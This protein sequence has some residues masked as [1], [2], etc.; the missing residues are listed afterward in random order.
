[1]R[2][3]YPA[4]TPRAAV[5]RADLLRAL[6]LREL[7]ALTLDDDGQTWFGYRRQEEPPPLRAI[8]AVVEDAY[9]MEVE[10]AP[11]PSGRR[12][13]LRMPAV[14][15]IV[16]RETRPAPETPPAGETFSP[17]DE[18]G[19]TP[20]SP[21][22]LIAYE[23]LIPAAR[24]LPALRRWLG[25]DRPGPP[26]LDRL[27]RRLAVADPPRHLPRQRLSRWHPDLVVVFDFS[28]RLWPYREDMHRLAERLLR[29]CGQYGVSPRIV[30]R[31]PPG[32]WTDWRDEQNPA[33]P[34]TA[35]AWVMPPAGTPVLIVGDGGLLLGAG[36]ELAQRWRAFIARLRQARLRPLALV[37]L[38]A[39]QLDAGLT[40]GLPVLR[41]SPDARLRP[42]RAHGPGRPEPE[43]LEDLLAMAAVPRR[44]DPPLLRALRR[45]HPATPLDAGLEGAFWRHPQVE[46]GQV[47]HVGGPDRPRHLA[48]F[49]ELVPA[50]QAA[51]ERLRARHHAHLRAV[52]HHEETLAFAAHADPALLDHPDLAAAVAESA[53]F[54]R[55]LAVTLEQGADD[56]NAAGWREAA[57]GIE[58]RAD[59]V[60][61]ER[62]KDWL[63]PLAAARMRRDLARGLEPVAPDWADPAALAE[64]LPPGP[65]VE[66]WLVRDAAG[67]GLVLQDRPA[68]PRQSS[69]GPPDA[70]LTL[71]GGGLSVRIGAER[72]RWHPADRLPLRLAGLDAADPIRLE[73]SREQLTI[74]PLVRPR[75]TAILWDCG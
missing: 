73:T 11:A 39:G 19:P 68:G 25:A 64:A 62:G 31:G 44:I 3:E 20:K 32:V 10:A 37:P 43:G 66:A 27:A 61:A 36:S 71:D 35:R 56:P 13:P 74:A 12:P 23:D 46:S 2:R 22:R 69:V 38:G 65:T 9:R 58:T 50:L 4:S 57:R 51:L 8:Q 52:L 45:L 72:S 49:R 60:M 55:R 70:P 40:R 21:V 47:A 41:W 6:A 33:H 15:G 5:G 24:L 18:A 59:T 30:E 67:A 16:Q 26:D 7:D 17:L 29:L 34:A 48:R 14:L 42:E 54:M 28:P 1:M 63:L 53:D 75:G